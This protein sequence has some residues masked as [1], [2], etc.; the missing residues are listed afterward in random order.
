MGR[1]NE[2]G[3]VEENEDL[4]ECKDVEDRKDAEEQSGLEGVGGLVDA[5]ASTA[6]EEPSAHIAGKTVIR[7]RI[8]HIGSDYEAPVGAGTCEICIV[9]WI[10]KICDLDFE[11]TDLETGATWDVKVST[12][13]HEKWNFV[14]EYG[15]SPFVLSHVLSRIAVIVDKLRLADPYGRE[16]IVQR[17]MQEADLARL[18]ERIIERLDGAYIV[19]DEWFDP[20]YHLYTRYDPANFEEWQVTEGWEFVYE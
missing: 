3:A 5:Q 9:R 2:A 6:E 7:L 14:W 1:Q 10:A 12:L 8:T 16:L 13:H 18:P 15:T 19:S 20:D 11:I 17:I 4:E